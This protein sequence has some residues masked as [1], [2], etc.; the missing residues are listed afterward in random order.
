[1]LKVTKLAEALGAEVEG[2]DLSQRIEPRRF[3]ELRA[4]W[5][6]HLVLRIR[7][8]RLVRRVHVRPIGVAALRRKLDRVEDRRHRRALDVGHVGVPDRLAVAQPADRHAV[9]LDVGDHVHLGMVGKE[10][11][12][13]RVRP[14]RVELA[15]VAAEREQLRIGEALAA[16]SDHHVLEPRRPNLS[17]DFGWN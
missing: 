11:A 9:L 12:P 1:M 16:D 4:A 13:Q 14:R 15:E 7:G 6:E 2:L 10:R 3:A 5:L 8:Q 17:K